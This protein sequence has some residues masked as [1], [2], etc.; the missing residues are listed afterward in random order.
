VVAAGLALSGCTAPDGATSSPLDALL[1]RE[2]AVRLDEDPLF[3][4]RVGRHE[5]GHRLPEVGAESQAR[6]DATWRGMLDEL[7]A[8]DASGLSAAK[9]VDYAIFE[10]QLEDRIAGYRFGAWQVPFNADSGF[11]IELLGLPRQMPFGTVEDYERYLSRLRA[12]PRYFDEQ[13]RN[14]RIGLE[15]GMTV[16]RVVLEGYEATIASHV[17]EEPSESVLWAPLD[18]LPATIAAGEAERLREAARAA[19]ADAVVPAYRA[20]LDFMLGE[21]MPGARVTLGASEL[22]DGAEYYAQRVRHFTTLDRTPEEIHRI[23]LSEVARIR[24]EMQ[25]IVDELGFEGGF[26][27]FLEFLRNDSRFQAASPEAL[28]MRAAWL[29]K[30][31]DG[32][33][34]AL[35]KTLPRLPY[36]VEPVPDHIAP[37]YTAGR[38]VSA[39]RG[40]TRAGTY[41]VNTYDLK[42]R[43]LYTLEALTLH[44]AV[45]G[46]HLQ[47]ALSNELE[48][49]PPFR[50]F[51]YISAFGEGWGLYAEWL[52]LEAGFYAD[53]YSNFGRLTYE[54]WRACRL[55]V[56]TGIHAKGW[57]REQVIDYLAANT[58]LSRHEIHTETD[59]YISW[60]G[61]ALAYKMGELKIRELRRRAERELGERF[62]VREFHD[63][64]LLNGSVPLPVLE[65]QIERYIRSARG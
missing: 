8:I 2:W 34:P 45:P 14:M 18:E 20:F 39:A 42:S 25:R 26:G 60:P 15:R 4:T 27:A 19:I 41:W 23:G 44:E 47:I 43:T 65:Q 32:R 59:R 35:F 13:I 1:E 61:Q 37:K 36:G 7:H 24:A 54:M 30:R 64:V 11:H 16:P 55:V 48:D 51:T 38:Y 31:M 12:F 49:L 50:R 53:P 56:D 22:P 29:A 10:R 6:R 46:H 3:A 63:A 58:A 5:N 52:G 33:L 28:L 9:Q 17:V 40:S 57:A 21:Y 62:D